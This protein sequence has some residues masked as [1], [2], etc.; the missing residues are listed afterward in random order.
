VSGSDA[1][2]AVRLGSLTTA[3]FVAGVA[4][5]VAAIGPPL[6]LEGGGK[7][8]GLETAGL[9]VTVDGGGKSTG[10]EGRHGLSNILEGTGKVR[11][12]D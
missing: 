11:I 8:T 3:A 5:R 4:I 7:S 10:R 6:F 1:H 12:G 2:T 9:V